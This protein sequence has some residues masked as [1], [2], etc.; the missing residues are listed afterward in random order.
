MTKTKKK[1]QRKS[2]EYR[3]KRKRSE[4]IKVEGNTYLP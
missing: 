2:N 1:G 3:K 4:M